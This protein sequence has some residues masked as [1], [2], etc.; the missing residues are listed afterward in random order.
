[1]SYKIFN[2]WSIA[3]LVSI[4][5]RERRNLFKPIENR[6]LTFSI[7]RQLIHKPVFNFE[8]HVYCK[9]FY[10]RSIEIKDKQQ[11]ITIVPVK[12]TTAGFACKGC[13]VYPAVIIG[14][15]MFF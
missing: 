15:E 1:M 14:T 4:T 2:E 13:L 7:H 8:P 9:S 3:I 12:K 6:D 5:N 10:Q 11:L